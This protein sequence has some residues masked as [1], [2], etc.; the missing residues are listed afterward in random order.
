[1]YRKFDPP[2]MLFSSSVTIRYTRQPMGHLH[3]APGCSATLTAHSLVP[4]SSPEA[5]CLGVW[6]PPSRAVLGVSA[7]RCSCCGPLQLSGRDQLLVAALVEH[8]LDAGVPG[9]AQ[10]RVG[11]V[12]PA[13]GGRVVPLRQVA[14]TGGRLGRRPELH[15]VHTAATL[16]P[17]TA[18][19]GERERTGV[20]AGTVLH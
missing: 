15:P 16:Q 13:G 14:V 10:Q 17:V 19:R 1:M 9:G 20:T 4:S 2:P 6:F 11:H 7:S 12:P 3:K 5:Q 18:G 8:E